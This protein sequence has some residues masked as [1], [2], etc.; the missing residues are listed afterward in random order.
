[1]ARFEVHI[2]PSISAGG[3]LLLAGENGALP[4]LELATDRTCQACLK[5]FMREV[6]GGTHYRASL[7]GLETV[8]GP[9]PQLVIRLKCEIDGRPPEPSPGYFWSAPPEPP[10]RNPVTP[11]DPGREVRIFTDGGSRGNPGPASVG[12]YLCQPE[13]GY[14]EDFCL[15]I[16]KATNNVAE[17]TALL[18]GLRLAAERGARRVAHFADSELLVRQLEGIYRVKSPE[19]K[20][21]YE[22]ARGLISGF[23]SFRT[24]HVPREENTRADS[25]AN[26]ALDNQGGDSEAEAT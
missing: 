3:R 6:L 24:A 5:S 10:A 15:A 22:R 17:Y 11:L 7:A 4:E 20:V 12:V 18:E 2:R 14:E 25:L 1:M 8:P 19:L 13:T 9:E 23:R 21:L 26:Q 16:G